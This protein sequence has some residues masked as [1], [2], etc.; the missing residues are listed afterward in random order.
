MTINGMVRPGSCP[1]SNRMLGR[2]AKDKEHAMTQTLHF[3]RAP[4]T[5][6][7][8]LADILRVNRH[9]SNVPFADI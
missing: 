5:S 3:D 7:T 4:L 2:G 9:V 1:T 6:G 8:Q